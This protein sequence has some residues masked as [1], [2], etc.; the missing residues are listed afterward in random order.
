MLDRPGI[1]LRK[2]TPQELVVNMFQKMASRAHWLAL[3]TWLT[4]PPQ[5]LRFVFFTRFGE[6]D[7]LVTKSDIV[8]LM[9]SHVPYAGVLTHEPRGNDEPREVLFETRWNYITYFLPSKKSIPSSDRAFPL[10]G[11]CALLWHVQVLASDLQSQAFC[12]RPDTTHL[13][14]VPLMI[15]NRTGAPTMFRRVHSGA[16]GDENPAARVNQESIHGRYRRQLYM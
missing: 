9:R 8:S 6:L 2:E 13:T 5:N 7:G 4:S 12:W 10:R 15:H 3:H 14:S 11:M 1:Q 16:L